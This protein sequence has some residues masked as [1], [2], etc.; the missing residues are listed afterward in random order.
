MTFTPRTVLSHLALA[1]LVAWPLAAAALSPAEVVHATTDEVIQRLQQ[2]NARLAQ[3]PDHIRTIVHELIIPHMDFHT[4][5]ELVLGRDFSLLSPRI[6]E[7]FSTGFRNQLVERYSH[8]LLSYR[9]QD[10]AYS[11]AQSIGE[12]GYMSVTQTLTREGR[13]PLTIGYPMRP[14]GDDW[15]VIDLVVDDISLVRSYRMTYEKEI[16]TLGLAGFIYSFPEC[17]TTD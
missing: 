16:D 1:T 5:A 2:D 6:V 3:E 4:M 7:C 10:I 13:M 12:K 15:K 14:E 11:P 8:I 9:N 17:S